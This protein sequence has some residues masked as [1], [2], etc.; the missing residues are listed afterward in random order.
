ML[1][2]C[3]DSHDPLPPAA[4][5]RRANAAGTDD[6]DVHRRPGVSARDRHSTPQTSEGA[7]RDHYYFVAAE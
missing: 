2:S 6:R 7:Q 4:N 3:S 1:R 5:Q